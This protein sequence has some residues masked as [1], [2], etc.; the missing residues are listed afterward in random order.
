MS[1][2]TIREAE[3]SGTKTPRC[4]L[5]VKRHVPLACV[6]DSLC[7][8]GP[9]WLKACLCLA[10]LFPFL[11][12]TPPVRPLGRGGPSRQASTTLTPPPLSGLLL[13]CFLVLAFVMPLSL[14]MAHS[15][16]FIA[17]LI[18]FLLLWPGACAGH[19]DHLWKVIVR[20]AMAKEG[21]HY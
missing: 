1:R 18:V 17:L 21:S 12:L 9:F 15:C 7:S 19:Y 14:Q 5:P 6:L 20:R 13:L 4:L 3:W 8:A 2:G 16:L 10:A 11:C